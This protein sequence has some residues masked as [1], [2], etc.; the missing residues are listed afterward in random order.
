MRNSRHGFDTLPP[1]PFTSSPFIPTGDA[2]EL[3]WAQAYSQWRL[4]QPGP[5]SPQDFLA[6][7]GIDKP[8]TSC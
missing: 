6:A 3:S 7:F 4:V 1:I 8:M 5:A 2:Q